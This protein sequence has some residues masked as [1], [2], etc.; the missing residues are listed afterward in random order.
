M[1]LKL[2]LKYEEYNLP[3]IGAHQL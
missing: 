3:D 1:G 2:K